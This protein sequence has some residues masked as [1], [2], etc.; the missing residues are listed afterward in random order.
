VS[1]LS[2]IADQVTG[3]YA[4]KYKQTH[5]SHPAK[6]LPKLNAL[7]MKSMSLSCSHFRTFYYPIPQQQEAG[8]VHSPN[9]NQ[10]NQSLNMSWTSSTQKQ[11]YKIKQNTETP[12]KPRKS[13]E[14]LLSRSHKITESEKGEQ[15]SN[16]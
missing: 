9:V 4:I 2:S 12:H 8:L 1:K 7:W 16:Q 6:Q 5:V 14:Q 13:L 3:N 11:L 10:I 15:K